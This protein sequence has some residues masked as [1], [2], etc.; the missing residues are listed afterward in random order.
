MNSATVG[1]VEEL[2]EQASL[3]LDDLIGEIMRCVPDW[4]EV[5]LGHYPP[6]GGG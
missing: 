4:I 3:L 5:E 1:S 2:V 6:P